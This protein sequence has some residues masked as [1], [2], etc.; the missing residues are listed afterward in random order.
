MI[1]IHNCWGCETLDQIIIYH[2]VW[3]SSY[4]HPGEL[5]YYKDYDY[6]VWFGY[7]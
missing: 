3:I 6:M 7:V 5:Q 1:N 2:G 4:N